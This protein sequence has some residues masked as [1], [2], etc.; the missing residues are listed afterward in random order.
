M[1]EEVWYTA[2]EVARKLRVSVRTVKR[3]YRPTMVV[4]RQNRYLMSHIEAQ[5]T[6]SEQPRHDN[7]VPFRRPS[8]K[9]AA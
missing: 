4:G 5:A 1:S 7:V 8:R 2:L 6:G 3:R 9:R